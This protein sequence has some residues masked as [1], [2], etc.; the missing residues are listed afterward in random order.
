VIADLYTWEAE[1]RD[2][3]VIREGGDLSDAVRVSLIP[4]EH[5]GLPRHDLV[6]LPFVRRFMRYF[7]R[8]AV[9]G[10][11]HAAYF[12]EVEA[13]MSEHR[14]AAREARMSQGKAPAP[15]EIPPAPAPVFDDAMQVV[16]MEHARLYVSHLT[17]AALMTPPDYE[18]YK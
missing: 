18:L 5:S 9:G 16:C 2:G 6:G 17:G 3:S 11:D 1:L 14:I 13:R 10:F 4:A 7:K 12:A 15:V 8:T